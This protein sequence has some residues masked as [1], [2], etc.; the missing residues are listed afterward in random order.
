M[1]ATSRLRSPRACPDGAVVGVDFDATKVELATTEA[2]AAGVD[3]VTFR[4]EDV[5]TAPEPDDR[6]DVIYVRFVLTH[7]PDPAAA[8]RHAIARLAPGG[9]LMVEDIDFRGHFCEPPSPR[10][11]ATSS[12]TPRP[13]ALGGVT[14]TSVPACPGCCCDAGLADVQMYVVQPAGLVGDVKQMAALTMEAIADSVLA[15]ELA[16][17]AEIDTVVDELYA[18]AR[19]PHTVLSV[20]RVVQAWG[21]RAE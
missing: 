1:G 8:L 15:A 4:V 9:V 16:E 2:A 17:R 5:T 12:S 21:R 19:D 18:Y 7:L 13:R 14:R 20:P 6:F 3:N 10:S 11:T